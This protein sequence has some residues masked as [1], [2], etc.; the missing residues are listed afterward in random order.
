[1]TIEIED[2]YFGLKIFDIHASR[3]SEDL[4]PGAWSLLQLSHVSAGAQK[5]GPSSAALQGIAES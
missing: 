2:V 3:G 5:C 1:M 4:K